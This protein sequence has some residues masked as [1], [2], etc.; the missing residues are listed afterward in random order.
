MVGDR[1][2]AVRDEVANEISGVRKLPRLLRC[3]A[4]FEAQPRAGQTGADVPHV[5]VQL[6]DGTRFFT[7]DAQ[8]NS[9]LSAYLKK[10]VSLQALQTKSNKAFY[11]LGTLA[12]E[13]AMK[14]Q[15]DARGGMPS[16]G[17]L[18]W[19]KMLELGTYA[20]PRGSFYDVY[21]LHIVT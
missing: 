12:G 16:L 11:R 4:Q 5:Q 1:S 17:S 18:S 21:P 13:Q 14:K 3:T 19:S 9:M 20:P 2:W 6:P 10:K 8:A 7:R 15:F